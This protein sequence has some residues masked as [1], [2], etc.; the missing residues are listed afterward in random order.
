[1]SDDGEMTDLSQ[2]PTESGSLGQTP[3]SFPTSQT[4]LGPEPWAAMV[5]YRI[6]RKRLGVR[7]LNYSTEEV[8]RFGN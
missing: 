7:V 1:M 6:Y 2:V 5:I 4:E 8:R 3:L